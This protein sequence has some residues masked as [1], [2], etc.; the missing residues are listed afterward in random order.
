MHNSL[1]NGGLKVIICKHIQKQKE[2]KER[3]GLW[4][5]ASSDFNPQY[6]K[7]KKKKEKEKERKKERKVIW[8]FKILF[9]HSFI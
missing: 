2:H 3:T 4:F 5:L 8:S 1:L 6:H 7:K 9:I